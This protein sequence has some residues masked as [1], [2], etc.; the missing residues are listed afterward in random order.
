MSA[1]K[2]YIGIDAADVVTPA[3]QQH[4]GLETAAPYHHITTQYCGKEVTDDDAEKIVMIWTNVL[5]EARFQALYDL[6]VRV[7]GQFDLFGPEEAKDKLVVLCGVEAKFST[8]VEAARAAVCETLPYI[9]PSKNAFNPHITL[10]TSTVLPEFSA[11]HLQS[12][13]D[14][15][16]LFL[17]GD[18]G[19]VRGTIVVPVE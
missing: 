8:A 1:R 18:N 19:E 10:G 15:D 7:T 5:R 3:L 12:V 17:W 16:K 13:F 4:S 14:F 2:L 9:E 11:A 6:D